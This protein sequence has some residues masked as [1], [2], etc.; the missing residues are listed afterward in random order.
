MMFKL[1]HREF[2]LS[3]TYTLYKISSF[4]RCKELN[5]T[6]FI[7]LLDD[8]ETKENIVP[9]NKFNVVTAKCCEFKRTN[10]GKQCKPC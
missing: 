9:H 2:P 10:N 4:T 5:L 6:E 1:L 7:E 3:D 8:S